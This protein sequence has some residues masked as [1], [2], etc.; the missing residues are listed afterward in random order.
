MLD[1]VLWCFTVD[2]TRILMDYTLLGMTT[3]T[4]GKDPPLGKLTISMAIFHSYVKLP[5]GIW[6]YLVGLMHLFQMASKFCEVLPKFQIQK[7]QK[8]SFWGG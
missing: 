7:N 6:I 1:S 3:I 5:E 2:N 8:M 4:D